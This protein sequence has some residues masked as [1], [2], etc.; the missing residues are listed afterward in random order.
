MYFHYKRTFEKDVAEKIDI[1]IY[2]RVI[3][4]FMKFI[5]NEMINGQV[6]YLPYS[7]GNIFVQRKKLTPYFEFKEM[8]LNHLPVDYEATKKL[9]AERPE[10]K[11]KKHLVYHLNEH[12]DG[13]SFKI[14]WDRRTCRVSNHEHYM[15]K[16][17]RAFS[18]GLAKHL[19]NPDSELNYQEKC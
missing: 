12:T 9:W 18:R 17:V 15:F 6:F 13:Y 10:F 4:D 7:L 3:N 14:C 1:K 19:K 2:A 5:V 11:A 8:K 16:P